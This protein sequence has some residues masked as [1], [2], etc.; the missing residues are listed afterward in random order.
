MRRLLPLLIVLG[1]VAVALPSAAQRAPHHRMP[2]DERGALLFERH[3]VQC[4]GPTLAGDGPATTD[5]IAEVPDLRGEVGRARHADLVPVVLDGQ[6]AMPGYRASFGAA[7][8]RRV[9]R[10]MAGLPTEE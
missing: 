2:D 7:D 6:G 9:L 3:C 1:V 5:L 10:H 4:H 8:A